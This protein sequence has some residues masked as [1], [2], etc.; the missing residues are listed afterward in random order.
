MMSPLK[1]KDLKEDVKKV[2]LFLTKQEKDFAYIVLQQKKLEDTVLRNA[3]D[4]EITGRSYSLW[5]SIN[6]GDNSQDIMKYFNKYFKNL[7]A[8]NEKDI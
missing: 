4:W 1:I 6:D 2:A 5:S 7:L 8:K 3:F